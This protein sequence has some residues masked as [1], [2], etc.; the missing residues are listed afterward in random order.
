[1]KTVVRSPSLKNLSR[2]DVKQS[3]SWQNG[4]NVVNIVPTVLIANVYQ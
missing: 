3:Q 1:M 4:R 2:N